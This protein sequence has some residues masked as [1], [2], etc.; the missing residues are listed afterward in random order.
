MVSSEFPL[1]SR[2]LCLRK[3]GGRL[4]VQVSLEQRHHSAG[5]TEEAQSH[6]CWLPRHLRPPRTPSK[7]DNHST[8][9]ADLHR[10]LPVLVSM[11]SAACIYIVLIIIS[12]IIFTYILYF[13]Y[14]ILLFR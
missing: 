6:L 13:I 5:G 11:Q 2:L 8:E 9:A 7:C 1:W 12:T 4:G 14:V 3:L 10:T